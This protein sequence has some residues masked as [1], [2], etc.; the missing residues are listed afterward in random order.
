[1]FC[2]KCD[3]PMHHV[4][5]FMNGRNYELYRCPCC[6]FESKPILYSL[7]D[8]IRQKSNDVTKTKRRRPKNVQRVHHHNKRNT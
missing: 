8:K 3:L 1:M 4:L 2:K 5:R 7:P 6:Y